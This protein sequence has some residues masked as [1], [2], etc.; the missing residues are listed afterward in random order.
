MMKLRGALAGLLFA[1]LAVTV[2]KGD[3]LIDD[4]AVVNIIQDTN[5]DTN[6]VIMGV[7][8]SGNGLRIYED[9]TAAAYGMVVG[10]TADSTNNWVE[11]R[12]NAGLVLEDSLYV[13]LDSSGNQLTTSA[14]AFISSGGWGIIGD[15]AGAQDNQVIIQGTGSSWIMDGNLIVGYDGNDNELQVADG[16]LVA[17]GGTLYIGINST[18]DS[19]MMTVSNADLYVEYDVAVGYHGA[20][21]EL[22]VMDGSTVDAYNTYVG[23]TNLADNNR[24]V[25]TDGS[26][27]VNYGGLYIGNTNNTGNMMTV[28]NG[29]FLV[30][31]DELRI[32][33]TG[34]A[35]NLERGGT[36]L[37]DTNFNA[38]MDGFN[39]NEG[40]ALYVGGVLSGAADTIEGGRTLGLVG[41]YGWWDQSG[42]NVIVGD[43]TSSNRLYLSDGGRVD[44]GAVFVGQNHSSTGNEVLVTGAGTVL[45][46]A[47]SLSIGTESNA[48]NVV[49]V[50]NG[51][52]I[53]LG[54]DLV[55]GGSSNTFNLADGGW[56][57][58]SNGLDASQA[59]FNFLS[60]GTLESMGAL[61]GMDNSI[62]DGRAVVLTGSNAVW[63][64]GTNPLYVGAV[65]SSNDL[66]VLDGA[67]L[68]SGAAAIGSTGTVGN[69]VYISGPG[70]LW[71]NDGDLALD[72]VGNAL[73]LGLEGGVTV[74]NTLSVHNGATLSFASGGYASASNYYQDASSVFAFASVTNSAASP[75]LLVVTNAAEFEGGATLHYTGTISGLERGVVYTNRLVSADT[76]IVNG[77]TN[78][79]GS[80][81]DALTLMGL[82]SLLSI[83]LVAM[84]DDLLA[85]IS[86]MSLADSA[87]FEDGTDMAGVSDA[88]DRLADDGNTLAQNMINTLSQT[89]SATQNATLSQL[90]DR[91]A[92][93]YAHTKGM[94][95][96]F[97]QVRSQGVMPT[98]MLP[99]GA[100]G[101]H[102]YGSQSQVWAKG[103][104]SWGQRDA[105]DSFSDYDQSVYGALLGMDKSYGELMAG[106]AGGMAISDISQDDGDS[107]EATT[108]YG[109]L[110][111]SVG[112]VSWFGDINLGYGHSKI[113]D[114]SG[115]MF[116]TS[117][118]YTADQ[119]GFY[120]GGGKE[121][122]FSDDRL[123]ITPSAAMSGAYYLQGGYTEHSTTAV[124][125]SVDEYDYLSYRSEL[126]LKTLYTYELK[127]TILMP[128]VHVN[129]LHEFNA[130]EQRIGYSLVGDSGRYSFGLPAPVEDLYEVG[131][132]LSWWKNLGGNGKFHEWALGV[133]SRFG[134]GYM[135]TTASLRLLSRF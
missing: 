64:L 79:T 2:A 92:P 33:G 42:T 75:A 68:A 130:D 12:E 122:V 83:D 52:A 67:Y 89:D 40:S 53:R 132:L 114:Q 115:T 62:E 76:L 48:N 28:T 119:L 118:E 78:A 65:S 1:A 17:A 25:I 133:D 21:N 43:I 14:G 63:N 108:G 77:V 24:V 70:S 103:Y 50:S 124:P 29:G 55:M 37:V 19:N 9:T 16:A 58:A 49:E 94:L 10:Y 3:Y 35:F 113:E 80:D 85:I 129:W 99:A 20:G 117:A 56:L 46:V 27:W 66:R 45:N 97:R 44:A 32:D 34:N 95:D 131:A 105:V 57:V 90:Y 111:A 126:G 18:A 134:D 69:L 109:I 71:A 15:G 110:Y 106:L 38:A 73:V 116:N 6:A 96:A 91:H 121:M 88:I 61:T 47:G 123:F 74:G 107:S 36:L 101:P 98:A 81:L 87:G 13:G 23:V 39:Y 8:T 112:T 54:G 59:G 86:R 31:Y 5:F 11:L 100:M 127:R 125:R 72:G 4:G 135:E 84:D 93:T 30:T 7:D 120:L 82:G 60:G 128:E 51:G 104:G 41:P 102:L 26:T 22:L